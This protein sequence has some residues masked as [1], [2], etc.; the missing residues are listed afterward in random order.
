MI[1]SMRRL[2]FFPFFS[3]VYINL[4]FGNDLP[5]NAS[6][7]SKIDQALKID[8]SVAMLSP[9]RALAKKTRVN[10]AA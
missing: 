2:F 5:D 8:S 4:F 6:M 10:S 7:T 1:R 9:Q 3:K